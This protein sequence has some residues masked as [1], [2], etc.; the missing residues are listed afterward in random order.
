MI[1]I[2][3]QAL[4]PFNVLYHTISKMLNGINEKFPFENDSRGWIEL[5][6]PL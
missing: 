3:S 1:N 5:L 2:M 6:I 4:R